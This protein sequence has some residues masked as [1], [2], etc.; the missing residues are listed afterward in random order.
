VGVRTIQY[1]TTAKNG[2]LLLSYSLYGDRGGRGNCSANAPIPTGMGGI[3][4]L[5]TTLRTILY[6]Y[7]TLG[8]RRG[9]GVYLRSTSR[10]LRTP[11]SSKYNLQRASF[12]RTCTAKTKYR[13]FE[14]NIPRIGIS[15]S[16]SQF[17]HSYVCEGFIYSH[18]RSAYSAG[19]NTVCRPI[20]DYINR[21][22]T[23]ECGNLG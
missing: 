23:H 14:K 20:R 17:P 7:S 21:L 2:G 12:S 5:T 15:G 3:I 1:K 6:I 8:I 18:N 13:N 10:F 4:R 19:G 16:Q 22:Q 11:S 9:G